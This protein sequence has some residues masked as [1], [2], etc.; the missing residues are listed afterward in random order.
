MSLD[1]LS[2]VFL[3]SLS[4]HSN[5]L[6]SLSFLL[7]LN[8]CSL[9]LFSRFLSLLIWHSLFYFYLINSMLLSI[10]FT[11][12]LSIFPPTNSL[13]SISL[14]PLS[15]SFSYSSSLPRSLSFSLLCLFCSL[16]NH[17]PPK[18]SCLRD[19]AACFPNK[20]LPRFVWT[21]QYCLTDE[22][23][24]RRQ[25]KNRSYLLIRLE[26]CM[27]C[28]HSIETLET[29][30]KS[31]SVHLMHFNLLIRRSRFF[32]RLAKKFWL[33]FSTLYPIFVFIL[34]QHLKNINL[35]TLVCFIFK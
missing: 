3:L 20:S 8:S 35:K 29:N 13:L 22:L 1:S 16:Q 15:F 24:S 17:A 10:L 11:L 31:L 34:L 28:K 4:L 33:T 19:S 2:S 7:I 26:E 18:G 32:T 14:I 23:L 30:F 5:N 21:F 27:H 25:I 6:S 12:S 9:W